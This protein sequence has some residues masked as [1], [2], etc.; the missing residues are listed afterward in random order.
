MSFVCLLETLKIYCLH[1]EQYIDF[2]E[3]QS[4]VKMFLFNIFVLPLPD[5]VFCTLVLLVNIAFATLVFYYHLSSFS[6]RG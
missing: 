2:R 4:V 6:V 3:S 1:H 5:L